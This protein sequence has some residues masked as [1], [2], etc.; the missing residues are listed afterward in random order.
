MASYKKTCLHVIG[1]LAATGCALASGGALALDAEISGQVNRAIVVADDGEDSQTAFVDNQTSNSRFRFVGS[2]EISPGLTAGVKAEFSMVSNASSDVTIDTQDTGFE[3]GERHLDAFFAGRFGRLSLG[4]GD[5]AANGAAEV[6]LSGTSV[7][8]YVGAGNDL[9]GSIAFRDGDA[10]G[11]AIGDTYSQ[12]DFESRYDRVRYDTPSFGPLG[13]AASFGTRGDD[14]DTTE[15]AGYYSGE[16][17]GLGRLAAALGYS[18]RHRG[19]AEGSDETFGG[20]ASLLL[21][22][23]FNVTLS[24]A[25]KEND[26]DL[27]A[28]NM[29]AKLGYKADVHAVSVDYGVTSD[30]FGDGVDSEFFSVGYVFRP[31]GWAELYAGGRVHSLDAPDFDADDITVVAAGTRLKF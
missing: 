14:D 28:D 2:E 25:Q 24:Y 13:L 16:M 17:R 27:D 11:P 21:A 1:S 26:A 31:V 9:A 15:V 18:T 3:F 7:I 5:G 22:D 4:Q 8:S 30:L 23:G 29:Y 12:F 6:D 20:S 10:F 19:G